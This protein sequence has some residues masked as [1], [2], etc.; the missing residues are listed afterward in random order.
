MHRDISPGNIILAWCDGEEGTTGLGTKG[1]LIDFDR[2]KYGIENASALEV[3]ATFDA[4]TN[5]DDSIQLYSRL[6][7]LK[8]MNSR[9]TIASDVIIRASKAVSIGGILDYVCAA[10]THVSQVTP[11][12]HVIDSALL[13]WSEV[14][15][16]IVFKTA[17]DA[18]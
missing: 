15:A 6:I 13:R 3:P 16:L 8:V 7:Q 1:C 11:L 14:R 18:L 17:A 4:V 5:D 10:W 9:A 2:G 12:G